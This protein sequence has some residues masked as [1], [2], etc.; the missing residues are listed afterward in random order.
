MPI[1]SDTWLRFW[2][3]EAELTQ[4]EL[5]RRVKKSKVALNQFERGH[6]LPAERTAKRIV[7]ELA[8]ELDEDLTVGDV[9][10]PD[11]YP[12]PGE[13]VRAR[14]EE[15]KERRARVRIMAK[16]RRARA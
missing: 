7:R 1:Y 13:I 11:G 12:S 15:D 9:F 3:E 4:A 2:R 14:Y 16:R 6:K 5:A 10:P 8:D